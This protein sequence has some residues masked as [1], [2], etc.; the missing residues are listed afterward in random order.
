[1]RFVVVTGPSGAGKTFALHSFEDAGYYTVDN[2]PPRLLPGLI[3]FCREAGYERAAVVID[4]RCGSAFRE[5]PDILQTLNRARIC[6]ETLFLDTDDTV[7][8]RRFKETRRPHPLMLPTPNKTAGEQTLPSEQTSLSEKDNALVSQDAASPLH[9]RDNNTKRDNDAALENMSDGILEAILAERALLSAARPFADNVVDTTTMSTTQLREV[10]HAAY[11]PD[12]RP[13]LLVTVL[14]FGFKHGLPIDADLVF[15]V[16][17]L[18]NPHYVPTLKAL[19]GR[20]E[21]VADYVH[22]DPLTRPFQEKLTDM[23]RFTLP[24]YER[25]GK[26]YLNVAIGCTGGRHRSVVVAEDLAR[27]LRQDGYQVAV[28]HRDIVIGNGDDTASHSY[29]LPS[30]SAPDVSSALLPN[31]AKVGQGENSSSELGAGRDSTSSDD[32][33]EGQAQP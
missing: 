15:D 28:R 9:P 24:Q 14:S 27:E 13:G 8:V 33:R 32:A 26:V 7:L 10:I 29:A 18:Q 12:T 16:R 20:D 11:A 21:A 17:F 4:A 31:T 2:L 22:A 30:I 3:A 5:L 6:V 19:N 23:A 25:E 1:M